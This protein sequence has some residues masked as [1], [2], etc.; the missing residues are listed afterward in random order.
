M[1]GVKMDNQTLLNIVLG[2]V[3]AYLAI[4]NFISNSRKDVMR[5][6]EEM[7]EIKVQLSQ[8]MS[9]LREVQKDLRT[10]TADFRTLSEKVIILETKLNVAFER[11]DE[12]KS[13][14]GENNDGKPRESGSR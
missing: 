11:I 1:L 14:K 8:V 5:E 4:R 2:I 10:S 13:L 3:T 9:M 12:L 7:T 6:S